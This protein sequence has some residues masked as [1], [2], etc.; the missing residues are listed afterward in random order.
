MHGIDPD[1]TP[2]PELFRQNGAEGA[3]Q[4]PIDFLKVPMVL[5]E[6]QTGSYVGEDGILR[7]EDFYA[8]Y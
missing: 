4:R 8:R 1:P 6:V 3:L 2:V 7:Y 5:I